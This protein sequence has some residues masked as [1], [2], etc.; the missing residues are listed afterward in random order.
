MQRDDAVGLVT[1]F[2]VTALLLE[3][4]KQEFEKLPVTVFLRTA[5]ALHLVCAREQGFR[6]IYS[7][8]RHLLAAAPHFGWRV[9]RDCVNGTILGLAPITT[10]DQIDGWLSGTGVTWATG[11]PDLVSITP[12][13]FLASSTKAS[14]LVLLSAEFQET[15]SS[16]YWLLIVRRTSPTILAQNRARSSPSVHRCEWSPPYRQRATECQPIL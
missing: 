15:V 1:W 8:D 4:V 16:W 12:D 5:D 14:S 9:Q 3:H 10:V 7:N 6:E 2:P 13:S 11:R